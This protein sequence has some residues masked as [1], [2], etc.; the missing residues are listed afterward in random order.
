MYLR[1]LLFTLAFAGLL[2]G[3]PP[4][5]PE[6]DPTAG[7]NALALLSGAVL[8]ARRVHRR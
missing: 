5:V 2:Y 8:V 4:I 7:V 3:P 6:I 1:T